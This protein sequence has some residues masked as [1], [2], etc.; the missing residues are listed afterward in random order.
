MADSKF[1]ICN[2]A[3]AYLGVSETIT[4]FDVNRKEARLCER[5][6]DSTRRA[7]LR[8]HLWNFAIK[9]VTLARETTTPNHE[10]TYRHTLP[11]DYLKIVRTADEAL[12]YDDDYRLEGGALVSDEATVKVEY[13]AD[14]ED[15]TLFDPLFED[16]LAQRLAA[17]MCMAFTDNRALSEQLWQVYTNKL[18]EARSVDSQEGRPRDIIANQWVNAR[19]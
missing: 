14:V 19:Y 7:I 12:C 4:T 8:A 1:D 15:T 16:A 18:V 2:R 9:R 3:L 5:F 17:E 13:V 11:E 6:Y 10:F